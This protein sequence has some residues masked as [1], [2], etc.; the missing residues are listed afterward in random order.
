MNEA[1]DGFEINMSDRLDKICVAAVK[2]LRKAYGGDPHAF[3]KSAVSY[4]ALEARVEGWL[5]E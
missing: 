5:D 1:D 4:E 3:G 2:L